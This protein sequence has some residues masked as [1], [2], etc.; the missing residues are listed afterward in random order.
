M[1][2]FMILIAVLALPV[3]SGLAYYAST[4]TPRAKSAAPRHF[5][6]NAIENGTTLGFN[7][8]N[9]GSM[10]PEWGE[11]TDPPYPM[12][13]NTEENAATSAAKDIYDALTDDY[14]ELYETY[15]SKKPIVSNLPAKKLERY[16]TIY[17]CSASKMKVSLLFQNL[18]SLNGKDEPLSAITSLSDADFV[19]KLTTEMKNYLD[20]LPQAERDAINNAFKKI[21]GN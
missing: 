1:P 16:M 2:K 14:I 7:T 20:S 13:Y 6:V 21:R 4:D 3:V 9:E 18:L 8:L 11:P 10:S 15:I 19:K 12:A 5:F 17:K